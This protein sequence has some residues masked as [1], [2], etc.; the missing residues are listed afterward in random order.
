MERDLLGLNLPVLHI[1]LRA[2]RSIVAGLTMIVQDDQVAA[3]GT[4]SQGHKGQELLS[5]EEQMKDVATW[6]DTGECRRLILPL[7][8]CTSLALQPCSIRCKRA[9]CEREVLVTKAKA[10]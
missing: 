6:P 1:N 4:D 7:C 10:T 2:Q 9:C 3:G 8:C 5:H